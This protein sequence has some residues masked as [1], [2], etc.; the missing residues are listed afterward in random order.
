MRTIDFSPFMVSEGAVIGDAPTPE[1]VAVSAEINDAFR[2]SGFVFLDGIGITSDELDRYY[3]MSG[4]LFALPD[5]H[6]KSQLKQIDQ[7]SNSGFSAM[8]V[9]GLNSKRGPDLKEVCHLQVLIDP[10]VLF[11]CVE[12]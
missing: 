8:G 2:G 5:E 7:K 1:Q 4:M 9:E 3:E 10:N 11:S 12:C 6:K